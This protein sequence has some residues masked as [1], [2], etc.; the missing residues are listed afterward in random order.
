MSAVKNI[1][2]GVGKDKLEKYERAFILNA[3][4]IIGSSEH[5]S[6]E[7]KQDL[8]I[9]LLSSE[10]VDTSLIEGEYL[11]CDSVQSSIKKETLFGNYSDGSLLFGA[12]W[13][14]PTD[15]F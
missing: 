3:G 11:N 7:D 12:S 10:A 13:T 5:L 4:V 8:L 6:K 15:Y 14:K 1:G 2:G 9:Q